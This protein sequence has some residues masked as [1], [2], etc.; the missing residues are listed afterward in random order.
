MR[1]YS[2]IHPKDL[3]AN[4]PLAVLIFWLPIL[5]I[6]VTGYAE[7]GHGL[8]AA[9]WTGCCLEMAAACFLNAM[10]C[11]RL[12]CYYTGPFLLVGGLASLLYGVGLLPLGEYGWGII[13]YTLLAGVVLLTWLPEYFLGRYR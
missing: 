4:L 7:V 5:A 1:S 12:Q 6:A 8:R 10:R 9:I 3:F 2:R 13:G 11:G